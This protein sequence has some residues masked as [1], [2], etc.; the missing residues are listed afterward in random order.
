MAT[1]RHMRSNLDP[2]P[3]PVVD[4][5]E[6]LLRKLN[7]PH[8]KSGARKFV[9]NTTFPSQLFTIENISFDVQFELYLFRS[10]SESFLSEVVFDAITFDYYLPTSKSI[11]S[12]TNHEL[13]SNFV[14]L[15]ILAD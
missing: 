10:K 2:N 4:D 13:W 11:S 9:R 8:P 6:K 15:Q 12:K 5:L 14:K 7:P 3:P 1:K